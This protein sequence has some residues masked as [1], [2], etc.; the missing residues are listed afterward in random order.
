[1]NSYKKTIL[2]HHLDTFGHVNNATYLQILEEARWDLTTKRGFGLSEIQKFKQGPVILEVNL[3]FIKELKNRMEIRITTELLEQKQKIGKLKQQIFL[4]DGSLAAEAV[5]T[6]AL[7]DLRERK[8]IEPTVEWK[9][10][11]GLEE[12][13]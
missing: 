3:K 5:F 7:F 2:E 1:M 12:I 6:F 9:R 8:I 11:I 13:N 4:S 10:A